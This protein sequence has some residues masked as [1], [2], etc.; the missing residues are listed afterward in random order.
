M[1]STPRLRQHWL[2][3]LCF[4]FFWLK[5]L[6]M[7]NY[8]TILLNHNRSYSRA[9]AHTYFIGGNCWSQ[10]NG[11]D[12]KWSC[13]WSLSFLNFVGDIWIFALLIPQVICDFDPFI[14]SE[15]YHMTYGICSLLSIQYRKG[16]S[17]D[18]LALI[19]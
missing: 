3:L 1:K 5:T 4:K 14:S 10:N 16:T 7:K 15:Y 17:A 2:W 13:W 8:L 19:M 6:L 11:E 12:K 18:Q 9:K